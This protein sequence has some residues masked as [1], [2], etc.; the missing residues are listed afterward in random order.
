MTEQPN[1]L[2]QHR[3]AMKEAVET[4]GGRAVI[5]Y[6]E[7]FDSDPLRRVLYIASKQVLAPPDFQ[8][9][10]LD[11]LITVCEAG[12]AEMLRQA[13]A[14]SDGETQGQ[15]I[16]EAHI[17]SY[18][19]A[20][21]LADCWPGDDLPRTEAHHERGVQAATDCLLWSEIAGVPRPISSDYWVRG[22]HQLALGDAQ[23]AI[24]SWTA[25]LEFAEAAA[26]NQGAATNVGPDGT[27]AVILNSGYLGLARWVS[28]EGTGK[29]EYEAALHAFQGQLE[30][31][32][33]AEDAEKAGEAKLGIGQLDKTRKQHGP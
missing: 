26:E 10:R 12:L 16:H 27:F 8:D 33:R 9:K 18:N 22:I 14:A 32:E 28:G 24:R 29:S 11:D 15:C 20:A 3:V 31:A 21:E 23:A 6:I 25:S 13:E 5:D 7:G 1:P 2:E 4:G 30:H 17:V 19:L